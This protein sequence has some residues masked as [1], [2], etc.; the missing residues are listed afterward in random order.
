MTE[1]GLVAA[2]DALREQL[3]LD[4]EALRAALR[5]LAGPADAAE[6]EAMRRVVLAARRVRM[7]KGGADT[8][9]VLAVAIDHLD[10]AI[11]DGT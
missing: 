8:L 9:L 5:R 1:D 7:L 6:I 4:G 10:D 11:K 2:I 3:K